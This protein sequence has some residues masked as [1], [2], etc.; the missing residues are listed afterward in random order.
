MLFVCPLVVLFLNARH[1][2]HPSSCNKISLHLVHDYSLDGKEKKIKIKK[3]A[4]IIC[5]CRSLTCIEVEK[6]VNGATVEVQLEKIQLF[7]R[8]VEFGMVY[9][10]KGTSSW[11][12]RV[13]LV[14]TNKLFDFQ[15][16][17]SSVAE[18]YACGVLDQQLMKRLSGRICIF[19]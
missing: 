7:F 4:E 5:P 10:K 14:V 19:C 18:I 12:N 2:T 13:N 11:R 15:G 9:T 1:T 8:E 6:I 17:Y 16:G 3:V